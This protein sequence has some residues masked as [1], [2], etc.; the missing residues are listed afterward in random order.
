MSAPSIPVKVR[1]LYEYTSDHP[2]DLTFD[3]GQVIDVS[4]VEDEEWFSGTYTNP[5]TG[6][7]KS[8]M[9]PRNFV[10]AVAEENPSQDIVH[11]KPLA[12]EG[13]S[14]EIAKEEV[15]EKEGNEESEEGYNKE[16][17]ICP[18]VEMADRKGTVVSI[19]K[20][21]E[22]V[23]QQAELEYKLKNTSE[24][25]DYKP[26]VNHTG[27][28]IAPKSIGPSPSTI[29]VQ[30]KEVA[31]L[32]TSA[33]Q[34]PPEN[35]AQKLSTQTDDDASESMS[36][37]SLK[38][39][40]RD[41]IA[42]FNAQND[43]PPVPTNK[44]VKSSF[45]KKPFAPD[46]HSS[47]VPSIPQSYAYKKEAPTPSSG[48][49]RS[50]SISTNSAS[51]SGSTPNKIVAISH[52]NENS[53][54]PMPEVS[55]TLLPEPTALGI[56][57]SQLQEEPIKISLKD[58]IMLLQQKQ[59]EE[60]ERAA[61]SLA[62]KKVKKA[63]HTHQ[64]LHETKQD[65][66]DI[67]S[68]VRTRRSSNMSE[69]SVHSGH[70]FA[71][72]Q[73]AD[74]GN[75]EQALIDEGDEENQENTYDE[76]P[77][78][79]V[80]SDIRSITSVNSMPRRASIISQGIHPILK[81]SQRSEESEGD[82]ISDENK[83]INSDSEDEEAKR[84][85]LSER[86]AKLSGGMGMHLGMIMP[87][88]GI[89]SAV[90]APKK[91]APE[92][93]NNEKNEDEIP[94][95]AAPVSIL[96]MLPAHSV[97]LS[98]A[99]IVTDKT[100]ESGGNGYGLEEEEKEEKEEKEEQ[101]E[102][103]EER[104]EEKE[105]EEHETEEDHE[106][107][108]DEEVVNQQYQKDS[109]PSRS[110]PHSS[111]QEVLCRDDGSEVTYTATDS[112]NLEK[113][114]SQKVISKS[115]KRESTLGLKLDQESPTSLPKNAY[116]EKALQNDMYSLNIES[117]YLD[118]EDDFE[119]HE[120]QQNLEVVHSSNESSLNLSND[121]ADY[122]DLVS[123]APIESR[124][125][126]LP[127]LSDQ[128]EN[129]LVKDGPSDDANM[130]DDEETESE[131][132]F[133]GRDLH[134]VSNESPSLQNYS[135]RVP[136][137]VQPNNAIAS[138]HN[139][140]LSYIG[141]SGTMPPIP[142]GYIPPHSIVAPNAPSTD[143]NTLIYQSGSQDP[144]ISFPVSEVFTHS[145]PSRPL[146]PPVPPAT[147]AARRNSFDSENLN[148]RNPAH[149]RA[150]SVATMT[151]HSLVKDDINDVTGYDAD[152]DTDF[153]ASIS[154]DETDPSVYQLSA[155]GSRGAPTTTFGA[156]SRAHTEP[157]S[158]NRFSHPNHPPPPPPPLS[159]VVTTSIPP[160]GSSGQGFPRSH[161]GTHSHTIHHYSHKPPPSPPVLAAQIPPAHAS[162]VSATFSPTI[163]SAGPTMRS[164]IDSVRPLIT[165]SIA[166]QDL[167]LSGDWWETPSDVPH[168]LKQKSDDC[169]Y[170]VE[171]SEVTKRGGKVMVTKD[172]YI[173]YHDYSQTV[174]SVQF[175]RN[176]PNGVLVTQTHTPPPAVPSQSQL[177]QASSKYGSQVLK[178]AL[179]S[180]NKSFPTHT[181]VSSLLGRIPGAL[182]SIGSKTHGALVYTNLGNASI[183]QFDEIRN[184]DII[185]F[186]KAK[187]QGH[188]G[189][190]RQKYS[191]EVGLSKIHLG[192]VYEWDGTKKKV[193]VIEQSET[194][195][196]VKH[197][198]YKLGDLKSGE[199]K[200][201]RAMDRQ[202]VGWE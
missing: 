38:S 99:P 18:A 146:P 108:D 150:P 131:V 187:F 144:P 48:L 20:K 10:E 85:A 87:G 165:L 98:S 86:M 84:I 59:K 123:E 184:G 65:L 67:S 153:N 35:N 198:S 152:E 93:R 42:A 116:S 49:V 148:L 53:T 193:R 110:D 41:R 89:P 109:F 127:P 9:F 95:S 194:N 72:S 189:S 190:L 8:G 103:E 117:E 83:S 113:K 29:S 36:T 172:I 88:F 183:Q 58:R 196:K 50:P 142:S 199:I 118:E 92:C 5:W 147:L 25:N 74:I 7:L 94:K 178:L 145:S 181:L 73:H 52:E 81:E 159:S 69:T 43:S 78:Q 82:A 90:S 121:E 180:L 186:R 128:L 62:K 143:L 141:G 33:H 163:R 202:Y 75:R 138:A 55:E 60:Q 140:R 160:S 133:I 6:V 151:R 101:V 102:V 192:V 31:A 197:E 174:I 168:V 22:P 34:D 19:E 1:A 125:S 97:G 164:S 156:P 17:K 26:I 100:I 139:K 61:A 173:L 76:A 13:F 188:K 112:S 12:Q 37:P 32:S 63:Q 130:G 45:V 149:T 176:D 106:K 79:D 175:D 80:T 30:S 71:Y 28:E 120:E 191:S 195:G 122:D 21:P 54:I 70:S 114:R 24:E 126:T 179:A 119:E 155:P 66:D 11:H 15:E 161:Q 57:E 91:K 170:E 105:G 2:D 46:A 104:E 136:V 23:Y 115:A 201:F 134:G 158:A 171:E 132:D 169:I 185:S 167:N 4:A 200:V 64:P 166:A 182:R 14:K 51:L 157:I 154:F 56:S 44:E 77:F 27:I 68:L 135:P 129:S 40:F 96:P 162:P 124:H 111:Q 39:S 16:E 47:Y 137:P 177:E 3:V 107:D